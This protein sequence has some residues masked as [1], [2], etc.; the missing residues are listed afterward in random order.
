MGDHSRLS[1]GPSLPS[2]APT[3]VRSP[4]SASKNEC[5]DL[6]LSRHDNQAH[7]ISHRPDEKEGQ[8]GNQAPMGNKLQ[9]VAHDLLP[10]APGRSGRQ[11][12][13]IFLTCAASASDYLRTYTAK[14]GRL[15]SQHEIQD[16]K[17]CYSNVSQLNAR[18]RTR[19][20]WCW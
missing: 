9:D 6:P 4:R 3:T 11:S 17:T 15:G 7:Q 14:R 10:I 16:I 2:I 5:R 8:D 19:R 13:H 18:V 20:R 12:C 1:H